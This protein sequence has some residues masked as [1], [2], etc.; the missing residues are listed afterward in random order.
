MPPRADNARLPPVAST[1][2]PDSG[3][4]R[5]EALFAEAPA[6][7]PGSG[8]ADAA[9]GVPAR[10]AVRAGRGRLC[11]RPGTRVSR[12]LLAVAAAAV[13][14]G[15]ASHLA[16]PAAAPAAPAAGRC[17]VEPGVCLLGVPA[18]LD[19]GGEAPGWRC[20]GL[21]GGADA[22][23]AL[24]E[25]PPRQASTEGAAAR[26]GT[27]RPA[28]ASRVGGAGPPAP[29]GAEV[30]P[31]R[32]A[33][34]RLFSRAE[35]ASVQGAAPAT[36]ADADVSL[37]QRVV[38]M[39]AGMLARA[40]ESVARGTEAPAVL[41]LNL[42][43]DVEHEGVIDWT[44]PTFSGGYSISGRLADDPLG[45]VTLVVNGDVVA[46][47]VRTLGGTYRIRSVGGGLYAVSELDP[48]KMPVLEDDVLMPAD[49]GPEA[50]SGNDLDR[51]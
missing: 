17:G 9:R 19:E 51:R 8:R 29:L 38:A 14:A 45:T 34:R 33:P 50:P 15:C 39:D 48:S 20:L 25:A 37:R 40:R 16:R 23:C 11:A 46:G 4:S 24:P 27:T 10:A 12:A 30:A 42:F 7:G 3:G 28:A 5:G 26:P 32:G 6:A 41:T 43:D 13:A 1:R 18:P 35:P 21:H 31:A 47:T 49:A 2:L 22:A 36:V 44:A